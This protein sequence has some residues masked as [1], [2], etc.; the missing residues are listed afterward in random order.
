MSIPEK[1]GCDLSK[2]DD[3]TN[4]IVRFLCLKKTSV[5]FVDS[6]EYNK[7]GH[8]LY[9]TLSERVEI[10]QKSNASDAG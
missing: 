2:R 6:S 7:N 9:T 5:I 8:G 4:Y 10:F 1:L 3:F